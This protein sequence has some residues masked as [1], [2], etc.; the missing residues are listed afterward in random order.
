[1]GKF[2][3]EERNDNEDK[4]IQLSEELRLK[5]T[6]TFFQHRMIH[7]FIWKQETRQL[8]LS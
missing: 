4:L 8:S 5:I 6:N 7:K 1:M 2:G 3:E